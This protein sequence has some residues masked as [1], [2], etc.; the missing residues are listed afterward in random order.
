[1]TLSKAPFGALLL[2]LLLCPLPLVHADSAVV[3]STE[4]SFQNNDANSLAQE[5]LIDSLQKERAA[6][7][8][9][10]KSLDQK[11]LALKSLQAE[12]D[13]KLDELKTLSASLQKLLQQRDAAEGKRVEDLSKM[14]EKMDPAQG[15]KILADLDQDLAIRILSRMRSKA[16]GAILASMDQDKAAA[17]SA[18]FSKIGSH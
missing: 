11:E 3:P 2:V 6:L 12:V 10:R 14:Y 18:A 15:A 1:M 7:D 4:I 5:R 8:A 9:R 16:A 17:L 13:K